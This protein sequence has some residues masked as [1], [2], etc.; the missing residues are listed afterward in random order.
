MI[1]LESD[2]GL[3]AR[4]IMLLRL[5]LSSYRSLRDPVALRHTDR[6]GEWQHGS[7]SEV[8]A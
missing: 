7:Q 5:G 1:R 8:W 4:G 6:D 3:I 2:D